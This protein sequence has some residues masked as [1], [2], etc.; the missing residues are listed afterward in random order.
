ME[1]SITGLT[2]FERIKKEN[3][4]KDVDIR[5]YS[6]LTLAYIGDTVYEM[7]IRSVVVGRGNT[8][9]NKLHNT[10]IRYSKAP[11][12]AYIAESVMEEFTEA[13]L[14]VYKRGRNSKPYTM[15]KNATI[16]EYKKATGLEAV[17]G[18]LYLSGQEERML[19]LIHKGIMLIDE[20]DSPAK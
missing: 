8:T 13:E 7:V 15:A 1:E 17:V 11:S 14:S 18:Y 9:P 20:K 16:D 5:T 12:Q 6:P 4:L 19:R 3:E 2:Y 10:C